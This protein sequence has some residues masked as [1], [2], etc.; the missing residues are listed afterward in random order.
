MLGLLSGCAQGPLSAT[1]DSVSG[2][3]ATSASSA[4]GGLA[5]SYQQSAVAILEKNC[6]SC[7]TS[8]TG[9]SGVYD[10]TDAAHLTSSGLVVVGKPSQSTIYNA[11]SS[12]SMPPTGALSLADQAIISE[13]ITA[14]APAAVTPTP[15][16]SPTPVTTTAVSFANLQT[17][18]FTPKCVGCHSAANKAGGYALD[19]Y[20]A[21]AL[22]VSVTAPS[23]SAVYTAVTTGGMPKGGTALTAAQQA[24]ILSWIQAGAPNN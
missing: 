14:A 11:I 17:T 9:P 20:A 6:T 12:G 3:S 21:V 15:T 5:N 8:S 7:H 13:W 23:S 18:I 1:W 4:A 19:T 10:L 24:S 16:P 2:S 22:A